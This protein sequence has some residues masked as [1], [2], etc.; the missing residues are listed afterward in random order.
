MTILQDILNRKFEDARNKSTEFGEV[1]KNENN[2]LHLIASNYNASLFDDIVKKN[3]HLLLKF[4]LLGETPIHLAAHNDNIAMLK[5][6]K[7]IYDTET[8]EYTFNIK[9][10]LGDYPIH[11]SVERGSKK[12]FI[13]LVQSGVDVDLR[14]ENNNTPLH[15]AIMKNQNIIAKYL[16]KNNA[17]I[18]LQ[19]DDENTPLHI[20]YSKNYLKIAETLEDA[21]ADT[22]IRNNEY[23]EPYEMADDSID[24]T[25]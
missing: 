14:N 7:K 3:S 1:D 13:F 25:S 23:M 12:A 16:I 24:Y 4:N 5:K 21:G 9:N 18:D 10:N 20:A 22:T 6:I 8:V 15:I 17:E 19:N 11:C 2:T